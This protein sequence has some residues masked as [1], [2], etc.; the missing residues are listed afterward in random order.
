MTLFKQIRIKEFLIALT[1]VWFCGTARADLIGGTFINGTVNPTNWDKVN[2]VAPFYTSFPTAN[3]LAAT[4]SIMQIP[5]APAPQ[6]QV[7][8]LSETIT[9]RQTNWVLSGLAILA[10]PAP[11]GNQLSLHIFDVTSTVGSSSGSFSNN[12]GAF[13]TL[14]NGDLLGNGNGLTYSQP[15]FGGGVT[16]QQI[17]LF[18]NGPT[19]TDQIVLGRNRSYAVEFWAPITNTAEL[20][21]MRTAG[22]TPV[23]ANAGGQ[24]MSGFDAGGTA[25]RFTLVGNGQAGTAPRT[26]ALALYGVMTNAAFTINTNPPVTSPG[27]QITNGV[28]TVDWNDVHQRIDGFGASSA[29]RSSWSTAQADILFSTN[30]GIVYTNN[31]VVTTNNG[32]GLSLL[33]NHIMYA[34]SASGSATPT[35]VETGIMQMAQARGARIWSTP[36]TP[37]AGFKSTNDIYDSNKATSGGINGGSYLGSGNNATNQAYAN[38]L[39][40][41]AASMAGAGINL[42]AISIQNEPDANVTTYEACQWT[43]QQIHDFV[44]NLRTAL[45]NNGLSSV[46]IMLPES[47]NWQDPKG[48]ASTTMN[49]SN[50]LQNVDIIACHNYD[51]IYGPGTLTK[52]SSGKPLWETEVS[53]LSG[54]DS[55]IANGVYYALR[56][57]QFMTVAQ[58]NAWHY[59]WLIS[60]SGGNQGLMDN[61]AATTKRLFTVGN[62][63][64]FVRPNYYRI[65]A[66]NTGNAFIS[67][68]KDTNSPAF[69][70]VAVNANGYPVEQTFSLTNFN[71]SSVTPWETSTNL[72]LAP[73]PAVAVT[74]GSFFY[75]L[76]GM[77]VVTFVGLSNSS[78]AL[79]ATT[80]ALGSS[81]S[82]STYGD[83]VTFT[84]TI[85]TNGTAIG[86]ISGET[87]TFFDGGTQL[88]TGI[89]TGSGQAAYTTT[90]TQLSAATH[91]ITAVY[92]GDANYLGSTNSPALSQT[93]TPAGLTIVG[94]AATDKVYDGTT[95]ATLTGNAALNGVLG[96]DVVNLLTNNAVAWFADADPGTNKPVTAAGY[97]ITGAAANNYI[98]TQPSGLTA[99]ILPLIPPVFSGNGLSAVAGGWQLSFSGQ[100]GQNYKVLATEDIS[101]PL[102]QWTVIATGTF[103]SGTVTV[104]DNTTNLAARFYLITSP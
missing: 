67:A 49:D 95:N 93:V 96:G 46:R 85:E 8:L 16:N 50:V 54:S 78:P 89:A 11:G 42:Y 22:T 28:C 9:P 56:I 33:R 6:A 72:S 2:G 84:A 71:A 41:Y 62:Y 21:W 35:T 60:G 43:N 97:E 47:Q 82:P 38:Q 25:Q 1:L 39:A 12:S 37:A 91:S 17:Y 98:L 68:Y 55:S 87:V 104:T 73:L 59:W 74:N 61:N 99:D 103:I 30:T 80:L 36:W 101:L 20:N 65:G 90:P 76:P 63:S 44:P 53:L 81:G 92:G 19:S 94:V 24:A 23:D 70:I 45:N 34:S 18:T 29:W 57:Y 75:E 48:L 86:N 15:G 10:G 77:S 3:N 5:P 7:V 14:G 102:D 88:G 69:A 32:I 51:G 26:F 31:L 64:R 66:T 4:A 40:N 83:A 58:I 13:Y 52:N 27:S 79:L 100:S